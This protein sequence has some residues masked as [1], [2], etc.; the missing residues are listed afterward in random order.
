[1]IERKIPGLGKE[2]ERISEATHITSIQE[3]VEIL[4]LNSNPETTPDTDVPAGQNRTYHRLNPNEIR[5]LSERVALVLASESELSARNLALRLNGAMGHV[6][7]KSSSIFDGDRMGYLSRPEI[8]ERLKLFQLEEK[9][10]RLCALTDESQILVALNSLRSEG[11]ETNSH[12]TR[13]PFRTFNRSL[14]WNDGYDTFAH[15][16]LNRY[17]TLDTLFGVSFFEI[18]V[19]AAISGTLNRGAH[20]PEQIYSDAER[21]L[22]VAQACTLGVTSKEDLM[23]ILGFFQ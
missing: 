6:L 8:E 17:A 10:E 22:G 4:I 3:I 16:P 21:V 1:M 5:A 2:L 14:I 20:K 15:A 18:G 9:Y 11:L 13:E 23:L 12:F 7:F 19:S